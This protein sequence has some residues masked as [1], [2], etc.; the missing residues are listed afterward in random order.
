MDTDIKL[1]KK[2]IQLRP[3]KFY[4]IFFFSFS[5]ILLYYNF[6]Q[7]VIGS[8]SNRSENW[9]RIQAFVNTGL[10]KKNTRI[11]IRN[12]GMN[13]LSTCSGVDLPLICKKCSDLDPEM[14]LAFTLIRIHL[15]AW[16][17]Y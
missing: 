1:K 17:K 16:I 10:E 9:I 6:G 12:P 14:N 11:R 2:R 3:D 15:S 5:R 7:I 4:F 13:T 8:W